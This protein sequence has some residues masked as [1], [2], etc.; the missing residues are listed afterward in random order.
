MEEIKG[1]ENDLNKNAK[2][3]LKQYYEDF[4][5]VF[6]EITKDKLL[7]R[8]DSNHNRLPI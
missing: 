4:N 6:W 1:E 3:L 2:L 8:Y 7:P 5:I